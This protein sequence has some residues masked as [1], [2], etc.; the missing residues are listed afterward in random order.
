[1]AS[2][3]IVTVSL[4]LPPALLAVQVKPAAAESVDRTTASQPVV[5]SM[6][7]FGSSTVHA[8]CTSLVYQSPSPS[9]PVTT[10][11]ITGGVR[12]GIRTSS[13]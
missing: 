5:D 9:V 4:L 2:R 1:M 8:T 10:G 11:V 13:A 7:E 3:L 6:S 12:S